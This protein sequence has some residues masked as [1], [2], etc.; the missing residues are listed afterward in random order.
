MSSVC[1]NIDPKVSVPII[2]SVLKSH[3]R[4]GNSVLSPKNDTTQ[5]EQPDMSICEPLAP[6]SLLTVGCKSPTG[7]PA[8]LNVS[9]KR[10]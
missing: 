3:T 5:D 6:R 1:G 7:A 2:A 8:S 9:K 10:T 4:I